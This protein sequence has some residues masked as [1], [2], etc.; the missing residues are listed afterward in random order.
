MPSLRALLVLLLAA[1]PPAA[2]A[3]ESV[4]TLSLEEALQALDAHSPALSQARSRADEAAGL[5]RQALAPLLPALSASSTYVRNSDEARVSPGDLLQLP[6]GAPRP[7]PIVIQPLESLGAVAAL[8]VPLVQPSAFLE[9]RAARAAGRG[10][11][12]G[13]EAARADVRA[14]FVQAAHAA[15]AAEE[16]VQAAERAGTTA[17]EHLASAQRRLPA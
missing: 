10:A 15:A 16:V 3:Q 17:A 2:R 1:L 14:G 12:A 8:R 13:A 4:R 9:A 11:L 5:A 7:G 6:P